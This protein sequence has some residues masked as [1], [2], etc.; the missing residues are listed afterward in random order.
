MKAVHDMQMI[1]SP[2]ILFVKDSC[3]A[4]F[5]IQ[6]SDQGTLD[7]TQSSICVLRLGLEETRIIKKGAHPARVAEVGQENIETVHAPKHIQAADTP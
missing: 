2:W 4:A 1:W 3:A 6:K 7:F 5:Y